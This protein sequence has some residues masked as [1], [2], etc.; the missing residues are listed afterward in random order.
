M[1]H[2]DRAK[3]GRAWLGLAA[4]ALLASGCAPQVAG[5]N[6]IYNADVTGGAKACT[7]PVAFPQD[8]Q[9]VAEQVQVVNDGGWCGIN[10]SRGGLPF[11]SYLLIARP[12][13]GNVFAHRVGANTRIDYT[14]DKGF[15]GTD[16]FAVRLL[17]GGATIQAAV[18]VTR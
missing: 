17:P 4:T 6:G 5:W 14:P 2:T 3:L 7:A 18:T 16:S 15:A 13:H 10:A 11:D 9:G 1:K 8:G 12:S